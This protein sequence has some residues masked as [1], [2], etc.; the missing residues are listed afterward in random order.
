MS[1]RVSVFSKP[2]DVEALLR[3]YLA[4]RTSAAESFQAFTLRV[5]VDRLK[6]LAPAAAPALEAVE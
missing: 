2:V 3:A 6:T 5:G 1:E 4:E